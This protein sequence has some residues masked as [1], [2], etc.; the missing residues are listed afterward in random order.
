MCLLYML[1]KPT[2]QWSLPN[3]SFLSGSIQG[4]R[5]LRPKK[6]VGHFTNNIND[7]VLTANLYFIGSEN[8][9]TFWLA[10]KYKLHK[11]LMYTRVPLT[12]LESNY[13]PRWPCR[14]WMGCSRLAWMRF[15]N[16]SFLFLSIRSE[17]SDLFNEI[18][19][20]V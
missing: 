4:L 10:L 11:V 15:P 17:M 18:H 19:Q 9:K 7:H 1:Q 13:I 3:I 12:I 5:K 6:T 16:V 14:H 2:N 8:V 20:I